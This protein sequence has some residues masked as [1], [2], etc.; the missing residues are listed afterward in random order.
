M[1]VQQLRPIL[2][3]ASITTLAIFS[4]YSLQEVALAKIES[5]NYLSNTVSGKDEEY[6]PKIKSQ[7]TIPITSSSQDNEE[8]D[9][10]QEKTESQKVWVTMAV[11]WGE[12]AQVHGKENF[13]YTEA[14]LR[15]VKLWHSLTHSVSKVE[16]TVFSCRIRHFLT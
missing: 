6:L 3:I 13:P 15:S 1:G 7:N 9:L 10:E 5:S 12:N 2:F 8:I 11:C 14:A 16:K 4:L